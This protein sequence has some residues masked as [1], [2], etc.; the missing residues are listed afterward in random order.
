MAIS[1]LEASYYSALVWFSQPLCRP[2]VPRTLVEI[3]RI[4]EAAPSIAQAELNAL[5][6]R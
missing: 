5:Y 4:A 1:L 6:W 3:Q 2:F